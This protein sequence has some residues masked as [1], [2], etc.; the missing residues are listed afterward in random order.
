MAAAST[1]SRMLSAPTTGRPLIQETPLTA[2]LSPTPSWIPL[3]TALGTTRLIRSMAPRS[4][5]ATI[6]APMSNPEATISSA[7]RP[8]VMAM[9]AMAFMG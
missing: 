7:S 5:R 4:A 3:T 9:A 6:R 2:S 1:A 8:S